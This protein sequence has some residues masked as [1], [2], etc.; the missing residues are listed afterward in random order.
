[1]PG[2]T[3]VLAILIACA[4]SAASRTGAEDSAAT[5]PS[6][7]QDDAATNA[8][9]EAKEL[10]LRSTLQT[11]RGQLELY[12]IQHDDHYPT[13]CQIMDWRILTSK[14]DAKGKISESGTYGPYLLKAPVNP[15]TGKCQVAESGSGT[16]E[17]GWTW[18]EK[19]GTLR[20][21]IPADVRAEHPNLHE[22]DIEVIEK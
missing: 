3:I 20:A 6:S 13:F 1:M 10:S 22:G 16:K 12:N 15:L 5:Q 8:A 2:R 7:A 4:A 17:D 21:V 19:K 18:D 14:T 11:I 9:N